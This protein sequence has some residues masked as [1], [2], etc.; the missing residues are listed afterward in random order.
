MYSTRVFLA[1]IIFFF[2]NSTGDI[3]ELLRDM[4]L[5]GKEAFSILIDYLAICSLLYIIQVMIPYVIKQ[6][7]SSKTRIR[8]AEVLQRI[9]QVIF[10]YYRLT[11]PNMS[12][13]LRRNW[14]AID[15][16]DI[17]VPPQLPWLMLRSHPFT[18]EHHSFFSLSE[19][20]F[21]KLC[22]PLMS[23]RNC[24]GSIEGWLIMVDNVLWRPE[25]FMNPRSF[26]SL[27]NQTST[28]NI[29]TVNFFLNPMSGARIDLPSQST[30]PCPNSNQASF[31]RKVTASSAPTSCNCLV[32]AICSNGRLAFLRPSAKSWT[33][34]DEVHHEGHKF[35]DIEILDGKLYAATDEASRFL[36]VFDLQ[37][38]TYTV[39]R[40]VMLEPCPD[41]L[42]LARGN[43]KAVYKR[44][45]RENVYIAKD[46]T[47]AEL[48]LILRNN[49]YILENDPPIPWSAIIGDAN[50]V[51]PPKTSGFRVFKLED[52]FPGHARWIEIENLGDR[53]LF[54]SEVTNKFI[55]VSNGLGYDLKNKTLEKNCIHFAFDN[56]YLSS[57]AFDKLSKLLL[58]SPSREVDVG[59][60]SLTDK[61]IRP[62]TKFSKDHSRSLLH[63]RP[64]WFTPVKT[65]ENGH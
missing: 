34:I 63:T 57:H 16:K 32:A 21:H 64:I 13:I 23:R 56:P 1:F 3:G 22:P 52:G 38:A 46:S 44:F 15:I 31:F 54:L 33:L 51:I 42:R 27:F 28:G 14:R 40:L 19:E 59:V 65:K 24:V 62:L 9:Y 7:I 60:F 17:A 11:I 4:T 53:V 50:F 10:T 2:E 26:Y 58:R 43:I 55:S 47:S 35:V 20:R 8:W 41:P 61:N 49:S 36:M 25:G 6:T 37:D 12:I 18:V 30:I 45:E 48:F 39:E 29:P 5:V